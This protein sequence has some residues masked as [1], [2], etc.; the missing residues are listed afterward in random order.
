M[1]SK[2]AKTI[3]ESL[4]IIAAIAAKDIVDA[5]KNRVVV[6]MIAM[7]SIILL[8]P[9]LLPYIFEQSQTVVLVYTTDN[10]SWMADLKNN[11]SLSLQEVHSE[12]ELKLALC[13]A[14]YPEIGLVVPADINQLIG[15]GEPV[16][17]SGFACWGKRHQVAELQPKLEGLLSQSLG[18]PVKI[19]LEGNIFYPPTEGVLYL[20][21]TTINAVLLILM[22]GIFMVPS[23]VIEE[24]ETKTMQALLVSPASITQVVVGK[25]LAGSFYILVSGL[26][27]FAITWI[28]VIHWNMVFLFVISS[29][30][31]SV[32]V[33]LVLGTLFNKQQDMA[34]WMTAL[35]LILIG[36]ALI[37]AL[38]IELPAMMESILP[39]VPSVALADIYRAAISETFSSIQVWSN[40]G[41]VFTVSLMLYA[42]VILILSRSDRKNI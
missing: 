16:G 42:V 4:N 12:Q 6:S 7:L 8:I 33:G 14:I 28:E 30:I 26:L 17:L 15:A 19:N 3:T 35:L 22:I 21:L 25:A 13:N 23:L 18:V 5:L 38:G 1:S 10:S 40:F 29:V 9:K 27:I 36:A 41:M 31:F 37:K 39:W 32:A 11:A 20:S 24:K 34:G 2:P